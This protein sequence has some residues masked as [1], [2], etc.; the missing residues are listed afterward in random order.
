MLLD[1]LNNFH[2]TSFLFDH[3]FFENLKTPKWP[4]GGLERGVLL[5]FWALPSLFA[6]QVFDPSTPS[7]KNGHEENNDDFSGH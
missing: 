2:E 1:P 6:K 4:P 5:G 3:S 7:I